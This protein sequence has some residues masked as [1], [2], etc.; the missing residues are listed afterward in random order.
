MDEKQ[1]REIVLLVN[2]PEMYP[3]LVRYAEQRL[4]I[5]RGYLENE[6]NLQ[7]VSEL[8]GAIAEIKRIFTL[9]DEV[10]GELDKSNERKK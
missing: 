5:L 3:L 7:K 1:A 2:D 8:Q 6:K 10:R 9:K 4:E